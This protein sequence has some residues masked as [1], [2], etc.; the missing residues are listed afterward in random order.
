MLAAIKTWTAAQDSKDP[1]Y[2]HL[3]CEALWVTWGIDRIDEA[4]VLQ[5]LRAKDHRARCVAVR[6][7]RYNGHRIANHAQLI[8]QAASD[9]HGRVRLEAII[10][11][12]WLNKTE[13]LA[14]LAKAE[15]AGVDKTMEAAFK[16]AKAALQGTV[17]KTDKPTY[18]T[19]LTGKDKE[20]F[21]RGAKVY[22]KEGH[23]GTCH[24][25]DGKGLPAAQFPPIAES[26][27]I[28]DNEER[29]IKLTLHGLMGPI[30]VKGVKYPGAVHMP[31]FKML[32]DEEI[33]D[34]LTFVRNSFGNKAAPVKAET[35]KKVRAATKDQAMFYQVE[36]LLKQHP[37]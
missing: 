17:L 25:E 15:A 12:S 8:E 21:L 14:V 35:V 36:D 11:A 10:A 6:A 27:W 1:N 3:L 7:L 37:K 26:E 19:H 32:S 9:R 13:G 30:E 5:L 34:V 24:Q 29:L 18:K 2:E 33:A 22:H 16:T 28:T 4:L 31:A 20:S 23:C